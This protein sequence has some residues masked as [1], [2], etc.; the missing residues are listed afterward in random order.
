MANTVGRRLSYRSGSEGQSHDPYG[1]IEYTVTTTTE[2]TDRE[3]RLIQNKRRITLHYGDNMCI[4]INGR[5]Y[6]NLRQEK[7]VD[8]FYK[9]TKI[10]IGKFDTYIDQIETRGGKNI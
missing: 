9:Y 1:F 4:R 5:K 8:I 6:S 3:G 2:Y 7:A 10:N